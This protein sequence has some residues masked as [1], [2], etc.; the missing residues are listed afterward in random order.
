MKFLALA[1][2]ALSLSTPVSAQYFS[3]GWVP[4]AGKAAPSAA[5]TSTGYTPGVPVATAPAATKAAPG[6][7]IPTKLPT[8]KELSNMLDLTN[9]FLL[10]PVV[11][12]AERFGINVTERLAEV[13]ARKVWDERIP[14]ITDENYESMVVHEEMT[15]EE[16]AE[17]VWFAIITVTASSPEGV[18]KF[19]DTM[20]DSA[21][22]LTQEE[23]DL[24]HVRWARIDYLNVTRITTKWNVWSAPYI[25][26]ITNRGQDLRFWKAT[27]VRLNDE[28][29]RTFLKEDGW[30]NTPPWKSSFGP[31]GDKEWL[32]EHFANTLA[33]SYNG[34][35]LVPKWILYIITG[36]LGSFIIG[37]LHSTPKPDAT[38]PEAKTTAVVAKSPAP[39]QVAPEASSANSSPKKK[40]GAKKR[41]G[42]K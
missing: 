31:G 1:L 34:L 30:K 15:P 9:L 27:Q 28:T 3:Q 19:A 33:V 16:E 42:K 21:F 18:S 12:L 32:M 37:L 41:N 29:I 38:K 4:G 13:K 25:M 23:G 22:N 24:K 17:R 11:S 10:P 5:T 39:P 6:F 35:L 20:F 7:S 8:M 36:A 2:G 40:G 14:L 26:V